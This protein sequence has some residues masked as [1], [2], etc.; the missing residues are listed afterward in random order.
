MFSEPGF[1]ALVE[2]I[3]PWWALMTSG[4]AEYMIPGL[5]TVARNSIQR[6]AHAATKLLKMLGVDLPEPGPLDVPRLIV[7]G[8]SGPVAAP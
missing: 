1:V 4:L 7:R 5:T 8:S 6:G 3:F 2:D